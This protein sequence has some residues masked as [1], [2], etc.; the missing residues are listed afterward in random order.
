[1]Y[2]SYF[3]LNKYFFYEMTNK[4]AIHHKFTLQKE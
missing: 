3:I 4:H 1:M 2:P